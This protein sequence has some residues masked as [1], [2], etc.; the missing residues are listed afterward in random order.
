MLLKITAVY[1]V[2]EAIS[3]ILYSS[4]GFIGNTPP[5]SIIGYV[6][7]RQGYVPEYGDKPDRGNRSDSN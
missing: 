4:L 7:C 3:P 1:I 5:V 2:V 6:K